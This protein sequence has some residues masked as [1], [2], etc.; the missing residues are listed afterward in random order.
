MS[1]S[2]AGLTPD[3]LASI[4]AGGP[5]PG[6]QPNLVD[7]PTAAPVLIIV[8][9]ILMVITLFIA[10]IRFHVKDFVRNKINADDWTTPV[11]VVRCPLLIESLGTICIGH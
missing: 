9:T 3:Q 7:P 2:L 1:D 10:G 8:S 4:P 6:I 5:P 11:A